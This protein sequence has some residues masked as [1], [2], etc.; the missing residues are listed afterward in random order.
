MTV[1]TVDM[2]LLGPGGSY[3]EGVPHWTGSFKTRDEAL[4]AL[5][6]WGAMVATLMRARGEAAVPQVVRVSDEVVEVP[7]FP[8]GAARR[9]ARLTVK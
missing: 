8:R 3:R 2:H 9:F 1:I 5:P 6:A 4:D 7:L